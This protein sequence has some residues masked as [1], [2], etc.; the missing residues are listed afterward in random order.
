MVEPV[1]ERDSFS[2]S[3][4]GSAW[5]GEVE[6]IEKVFF[7][8]EVVGLVGFLVADVSSI[9]AP[10]IFGWIGFAGKILR[11]KVDILAGF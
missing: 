5:P 9:R 1:G 6:V 2:E 4:I 3:L 8:D 11:S 10:L 7:V